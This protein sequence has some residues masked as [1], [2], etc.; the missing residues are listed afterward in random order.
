MALLTLISEVDDTN[1]VHRGG[2]ELAKK[3]KE[4]AKRL[5]STVTKENFK[6]TLN[7]LDHQY[8]TDNLSPGGCADLLAVSLMFYFLESAGMIADI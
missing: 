8:I 5:L 4:Q 6:E 7:S 2:P 1:M 3:S